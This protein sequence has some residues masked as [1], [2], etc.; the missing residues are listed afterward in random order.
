[1]LALQYR[2]AEALTAAALFLSVIGSVIT[3]VAFIV[4]T[5]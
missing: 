4:V 3:P 1:M 5:Q 2:L